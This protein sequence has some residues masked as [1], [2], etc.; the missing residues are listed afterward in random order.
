MQPGIDPWTIPA[1]TARRHDGSK[2]GLG[3]GFPITRCETGCPAD[4]RQAAMGSHQRIRHQERPIRVLLGTMSGVLA[5]LVRQAIAEHGPEMELA[6]EVT[7]NT[8]V[9]LLVAA[10]TGVDVVILDAPRAYPPP[11]IC[12]HLLDQFP[13]LRVMVLSSSGDT[14]VAYWLGRRQRRLRTVSAET[15][16]GAIRRAHALNPTG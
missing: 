5:N 2:E 16:A 4:V 9:D 8:P 11:G 1:A 6:T 3:G 7:V 15:L 13:H 14:A 10:G 12:S